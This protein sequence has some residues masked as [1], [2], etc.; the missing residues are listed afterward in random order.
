MNTISQEKL[1]GS[2]VMVVGCGA[3]GNEVLK[4][5][6][7]MGVGSLVLVDFDRIEE[8]NL[9]RSVFFRRSDIGRYKADVASQ[10]LTEL[11]PQ[12]HIEVIK[13]DICHDVGLNT[14]R[15]TDLVIGCV[16]SRWARF[17]INR[18]CMRMAKPWID[19]GITMTEGTARV[20]IPGRNCYACNL[21]TEGQAEL[22]RRMPCANIIRRMEVSGHAPT[23]II[24]AS[25]VAATMA[26]EAVRLLN[27]NETICGKMFCYDADT[28][29]TRLVGFEAYDEDCPEHD[30]WPAPEQVGLSTG[31]TVAE[32]TTH[33]TVYLR[34]DVFVDY[35][36]S[37]KDNRRYEMMCPGRHV[38]E[39]IDTIPELKGIPYGDFYQTEYRTIDASFPYQRLTLQQL[40]IPPGDILLTG[41]RTIL[42]E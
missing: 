29:Q 41:D 22:R 34:D 27:G 19:G 39:K 23:N 31:S 40:G 25:I 9:T 12:L 3:L 15:Q 36:H 33:G 30:E 24:T 8:R 17:M 6:V 2:R 5:L 11:N 37:R 18:H 32:A 14:I 4:N 28:R 38:A 13:G 7:F 42:I 21:G 10:R 26:N 16:D 20:F 1:Q 35:I